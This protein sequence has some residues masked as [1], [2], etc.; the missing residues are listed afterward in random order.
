MSIFL[1]VTNYYEHE[2][3]FLLT[4]FSYG[5]FV[6]YLILVDAGELRNTF[7]FLKIKL[8]CKFKCVY[9]TR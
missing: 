6:R 2:V 1:N 4:F 7:I 5:K 9:M 8:I 3:S